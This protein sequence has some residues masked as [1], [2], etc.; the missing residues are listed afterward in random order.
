MIS[1][2]RGVLFALYFLLSILIII[3]IMYLFPKKNRAIRKRWAKITLFLF[4]IKVE[5]EGIRDY[6]AKFL[7]INHQSMLDIIIL[8]SID[9]SNLCW[10]AKSEIAK[11]PLYGHIL[12]APNMIEVDRADKK[13]LLKLISDVKSRLSDGRVI[14]I[15]PEGTRGDGEK[16]LKFKEGSRLIAN[17][18]K[19]KVQP[20][21]IFGAKKGLDSKRLT[22]E[23]TTVK[24]KY[25]DS[26]VASKESE[27][28]SEIEQNMKECY[29][30][31]NSNSNW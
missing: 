25:L 23:S 14:A 7:M 1:K 26:L 31:T 3:A 4:R 9:E 17:K 10:I 19:L 21:L 27:W 22:Q 6:E 2:I 11:I 28:Y 8:E 15:F 18:F 20:I 24:I 13:G 12:K 30:S 16:L 5:T 29:E